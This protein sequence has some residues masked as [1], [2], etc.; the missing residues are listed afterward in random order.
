MTSSCNAEEVKC[1]P[2]VHMIKLKSVG[3]GQVLRLVLA[4]LLFRSP[5]FLK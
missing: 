3:D 2:L 5:V 4:D 1:D